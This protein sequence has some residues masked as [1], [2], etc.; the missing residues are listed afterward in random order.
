MSNLKAEI[1][2]RIAQIRKKHGDTQESSA[3]KL[4]IKRGTLA[5]YELGTSAMPD[6][7]KTKFVDIY[8]ISYDYLIFGKSVSVTSEPPGEYGKRDILNLLTQISDT[9]LRSEIRDRVLQLMNQNAE[10]KD[11]V[12]K[13]LEERNK[14][15]KKS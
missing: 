8:N 14:P 3:K 6:E 7:I 1:G 5:S 4:G 15:G 9:S 12:I 10:L 11:K 13:L 2:T